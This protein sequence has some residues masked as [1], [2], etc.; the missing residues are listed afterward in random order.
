MGV[1]YHKSSFSYKQLPDFDY[2]DTFPRSEPCAYLPEKGQWGWVNAA[3]YGGNMWL[4]PDPTNSSRAA[5]YM[6]FDDPNY[7]N[8][9]KHVKLYELQGREFNNKGAKPNY[10]VEPYVSDKRAYYH[11]DV[12]FPNNTVIASW[13]LIW[14]IC[15]EESVYTGGVGNNPQFRLVFEGNHLNAVLDDYY[16]TDAKV[17]RWTVTTL[18][19]LPKDQWIEF[20]VLYEQ[21]S[22]F[23]NEDGT[24]VVWIDG[25]K[26]FERNDIPTATQSGTPFFVWGIGCYGSP[27]EPYGQVQLFKDVM[28]T[29]N[30]SGTSLAAQESLGTHSPLSESIFSKILDLLKDFLT[31]IY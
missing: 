14:Q 20:V 24:V 23:K 9:D 15:G 28:V 4:A 11:F 1:I 26:K 3:I 7:S 17:H 13:R 6:S 18:E 10:N 30:F 21:G 27:I 2:Y 22:G 31:K 16:Y 12:W 5:L 29:S 19:D 25:I 8:S